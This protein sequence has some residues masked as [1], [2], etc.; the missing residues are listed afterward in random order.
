[1]KDYEQIIESLCRKCMFFTLI[2]VMSILATAISI[3]LLM[4]DKPVAPYAL[5]VS[6]IAF[7]ISNVLCDYYDNQRE[8]ISYEWV[9]EP[10][11]NE[12]EEEK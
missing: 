5:F 12:V 2:H 3:I 9:L 4:M 7:V 6:I 10:I 8:R 11:E 1:M